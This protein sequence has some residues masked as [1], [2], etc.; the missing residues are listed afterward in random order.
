MSG[1]RKLQE[2]NGDVSVKIPTKTID[3][4]RKE[5]GI[6]EEDLSNFIIS[7]I[8]KR[9]LENIDE[10]NSKVFSQSQTKEIEDDLKGLGYI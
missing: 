7:L 5:F 3:A 10:T 2:E 9:I 4:L 6:S 1:Q 8:E